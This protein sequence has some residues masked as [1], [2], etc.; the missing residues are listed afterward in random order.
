MSLFIMYYLSGFYPG[1]EFHREYQRS[2]M[3]VP[4]IVFPTSLVDI[5]Y[6]S[7]PVIF[8]VNNKSSLFHLVIGHGKSVCEYFKD[9]DI[10]QR[11]GFPCK[12]CL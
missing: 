6:M 4:R 11:I 12:S 10:K 5:L 7:L 9:K 2:L 3:F 8:T 1:E